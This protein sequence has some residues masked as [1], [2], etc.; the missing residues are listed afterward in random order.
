[1]PYI[2]CLQVLKLERPSPPTGRSLGMAG[3]KISAVGK[4]RPATE[5]RQRGGVDRSVMFPVPPPASDSPPDYAAWL[6]E[7]KARIRQERVRVVLASNAV[8]VLL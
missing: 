8:M 4:T 5:R 2:T 3:K 1:M 7:L 6:A